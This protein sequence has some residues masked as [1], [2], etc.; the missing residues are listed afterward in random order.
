MLKKK[1]SLKIIDLTVGVKIKT[2]YVVQTYK[3]EKKNPHG[4]GMKNKC[5]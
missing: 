2:A 1:D 5:L 3:V 4:I